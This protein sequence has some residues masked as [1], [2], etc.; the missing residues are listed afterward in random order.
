MLFINFLLLA[1]ALAAPIAGHTDDIIN[2]K[3]QKHHSMNL[4][5]AVIDALRSHVSDLVTE[6]SHL[7]R[8]LNEY[9]EDSNDKIM[10]KRSEKGGRVLKGNFES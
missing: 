8:L 6:N 10:I 7:K 5:K 1:L 9:V 2:L 4:N 3:R